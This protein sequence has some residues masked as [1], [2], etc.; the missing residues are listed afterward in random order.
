M[1]NGRIP[2]DV[3]PPPLGQRLSP[4]GALAPTSFPSRSSSDA[5]C[6]TSAGNR[7]DTAERNVPPD[8]P[9]DPFFATTPPFSRTAQIEVEASQSVEALEQ[10]GSWNAARAAF[11]RLLRVPEEHLSNDLLD[12]IEAAIAS[13]GELTAQWD[14]GPT[15]VKDEAAKLV[16]RARAGRP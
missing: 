12:R 16:E 10:A 2:P 9:E 4:Q 8:E 13:S 7:L 3:E 14:S 1:E 15:E 5:S 6:R 11:K